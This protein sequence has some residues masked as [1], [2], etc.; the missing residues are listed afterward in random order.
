MGTNHERTNTVD[1]KVLILETEGWGVVHEVTR[2][3]TV[4]TVAFSP[5]GRRRMDA[6][7]DETCRLVS[8]GVFFDRGLHCSQAITG[9]ITIPR[10]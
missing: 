6:R 10:K 2:E 8:V 7:M 3:G 9:Q 1:K 4:W 5:D